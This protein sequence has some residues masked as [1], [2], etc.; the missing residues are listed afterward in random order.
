MAKWTQVA[1]DAFSDWLAANNITGSA[2]DLT[3]G[4]PNL[5]R[6]ALGGTASTPLGQLQPLL[7]SDV[8]TEG[9]T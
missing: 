3:N 4:V 2:T 1:T 6:Y 7:H 9:L 8:T 5:I